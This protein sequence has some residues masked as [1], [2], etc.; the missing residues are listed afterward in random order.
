MESTVTATPLS[1]GELA[2]ASDVVMAAAT[3]YSGSALGE[4]IWFIT[5]WSIW[6]PVMSVTALCICSSWVVGSVNDWLSGSW[7]L[8]CGTYRS[9][10]VD[11]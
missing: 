1:A 9:W 10:A 6:G 5:R 7:M 3:E 11:S 2:L 8:S 4:P